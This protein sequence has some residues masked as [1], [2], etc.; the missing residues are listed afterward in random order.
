MNQG[1][2]RQGSQ[3]L[4]ATVPASV[5]QQLEARA[6]QEGR[7]LSNLIAMLLERSLERR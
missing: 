4:S 1:Y 3:R 7:S 6:Q 2:W 5:M